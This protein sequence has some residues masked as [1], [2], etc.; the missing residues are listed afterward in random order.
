L[1]TR[2]SP[3]W[4]KKDVS[5][6][7]TGPSLP[8]VSPSP[9]PFEGMEQVMA[10]I[11]FPSSPPPARRGVLSDELFESP[12]D[13]EGPSLPPPLDVEAVLRDRSR[14]SVQ[15]PFATKNAQVSS[16]DRIP[17][18]PSPEKTS[19]SSRSPQKS[20]RSASN[21]DAAH[22][23]EEDEEEEEGDIEIGD[24]DEGAVASA[25]PSSG[26]AS[27]SMSSLGHPIASR[28]PF[29]IH[30]HRGSL[31]PTTNSW[32]G[33]SHSTH[34]TGNRESMDSQS[35]LSHAGS[36]TSG[37][38]M[39]RRHP[40][41]SQGRGRARAGTVPATTL[42]SSPS[43]ILFPQ[44]GRSR[45]DSIPSQSLGPA[46]YES[47]LSDEH[48]YIEGEEIMEQPEPEGPHEEAE[49]A[50][51]VGLLSP[52]SAGPSPRTSFVA[53]RSRGT[54]HRRRSR[55][56]SNSNSHSGSSS[57]RSRTGSSI[58]AAARSR[59]Q[60]LIQGIASASRSSVDLARRARAN[61]SMARLEED[62][63]YSS[64]TH[65][66]SR[67]GSD[68]IASSQENY[69]F[70]QPPPGHPLH[71][72]R[73]Q[74]QLEPSDESQAGGSIPTVTRVASSEVLVSSSTSGPSS[75]RQSE[76]TTSAATE[77]EKPHEGE[78][79]STHTGPGSHPDVSTV[80]PSVVTDPTDIEGAANH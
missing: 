24:D 54:S 49:G 69:T 62:V 48:E 39:P 53:M 66:H 34:S 26:R 46:V 68:A 29:Q 45:T 30:R 52:P 77:R 38:P 43:P 27:G 5:G 76:H 78:E 73:T 64:D 60:S 17:F 72:L 2:P 6:D 15:Y 50:D 22:E 40:Q 74:V 67:S 44:G 55:S 9:A 10:A 35:P 56:T 16:E 25:E 57:S 31:S 80:V 12:N 41:Q 33:Y 36:S 47:N 59:T 61:S 1:T 51:V 19:G 32:S 42:S 71:P 23:D 70:G 20:G 58:S 75:G 37:I 7:E 21:G 8:P 4:G 63:P 65:S 79:A 18:P 13:E 3:Q 11:G 28:F 14:D